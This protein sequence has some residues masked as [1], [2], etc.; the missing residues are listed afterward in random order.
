MICYNCGNKVP[1]RNREC[2]YCG[3][4]LRVLQRAY[5]ISNS[6]YNI[7]LSKTK[8]RDLTGAVF[9]LKK[10]LEINKRNTD[11]RDL[12]GL[13]Y[14]EMGE[15]VAAISEWV[16][17]KHLDQNSKRS[18]SYLDRVQS[19]PNKLDVLSRSIKNYNAGLNLVQI[20][21]ASCRERV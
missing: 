18:E 13:I 9:I 7:G 16:I 15:T 10:S 3:E 1:I 21:R 5:R 20:G 17:S 19:N 8:V 2:D 4:D 14:F 12:L 11:A 6:Y